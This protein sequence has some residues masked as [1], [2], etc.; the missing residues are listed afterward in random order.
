MWVVFYS[1]TARPV[2]PIKFPDHTGQSLPFTCETSL[3]PSEIQ[4]FFLSLS[5]RETTVYA[6][7]VAMGLENAQTD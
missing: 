7:Y 3:L 6:R 4:L 5:D 2:M 1:G